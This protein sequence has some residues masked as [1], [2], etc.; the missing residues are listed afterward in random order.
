MTHHAIPAERL[1]I[2][3][4]NA[5]L[6]P[7]KLIEK[8]N[9]MNKLL[10]AGLLAL[11]IAAVGTF[12]LIKSTNKDANGT[13]TQANKTNNEA[14]NMNGNLPS[15]NYLGDYQLVDDTF[16]TNVSVAV[17]ESDNTRTITANALPNHQTGEFPNEGNPNTISAQEASYTFPLN[18]TFA[19][20]L[21][22]ARTPG[23]AINGIK[24]EPGTA[25][26][27]NCDGGKSERIEAIQD[28][29]D[30]GLDFNN[31]HVQPTGEYHYHGAPSKLTELLLGDDKD[32]VHVAFAADGHNI[33][34]SKS[35]KFM[36]S[37]KLGSNDRTNTGCNYT[38]PG[39]N[40]GEVI[41]FAQTKD[42]SLTSDWEFMAGHGALDECNGITISDEYVY[43]ITDDY[44][45]ISRC[46]M[47]EFSENT[48][49]PRVQP[50]R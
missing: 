3:R 7:T 32:L 37:Y 36:S 16:N 8:V 5:K 29:T 47:G 28:I 17:N 4:Q 23:V 44:P 50:P 41:S 15:S 6:K 46:L 30:L 31:A 35:G 26:T 34:Y 12:M 11:L 18:P 49:G 27:A 1:Y 13:A 45:Y 33:Y 19:G 25:E 14:I 2:P 21:I 22:E 9:C 40:G 20:E 43:F 24:L 39:P 42:G 10:P 38:V 48:P